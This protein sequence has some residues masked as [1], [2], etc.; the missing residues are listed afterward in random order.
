LLELNGTVIMKT[1]LNNELNNEWLKNP[2]WCSSSCRRWMLGAGRAG[3][4]LS[5]LVL[6]V[7]RVNAKSAL[8]SVPGGKVEPGVG[9]PASGSSSITETRF[10]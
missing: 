10:L 6:L 2:C 8:W 1:T 4:V 5:S 3:A 9:K 7:G